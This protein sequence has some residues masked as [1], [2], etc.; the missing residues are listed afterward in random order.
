MRNTYADEE[1]AT[2]HAAYGVAFLL[3]LGQTDY[4]VMA[5]SRRGTGFDYWLGTGEDDRGLPFHEKERLEVSGIRSGDET[6]IKARVNQKLKQ[7]RR[8]D[9][10][11]LPALVIVV[12]FSH[13]ITQAERNERN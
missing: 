5:K 2:E 11:R 12:E 4:T 10:T 6:Q 8:S 1:Y 13:P 7:V 9:D 3:V